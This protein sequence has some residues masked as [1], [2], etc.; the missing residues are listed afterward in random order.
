MTFGSLG[1]GTGMGDS[2]PKLREQKGNGK[3][4]FPKFGN[5]KGMKK[6][7]STFQEQEAEA[8]IAGN[9]W[10]REWKEKTK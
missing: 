9:S 10:E 7:I 5:G 4:P 8:I 3:R 1:T 6:S 2:I